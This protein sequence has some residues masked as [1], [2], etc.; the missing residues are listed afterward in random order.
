MFKN[1]VKRLTFTTSHCQ[2]NRI[3]QKKDVTTIT[4]EKSVKQNLQER[5][6]KE[7][8]STSRPERPT[9]PELYP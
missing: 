7:R 9:G 2:L 1:A 3:P 8:A 4:T 6:V 5:D